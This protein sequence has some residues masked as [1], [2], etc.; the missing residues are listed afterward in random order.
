MSRADQSHRR[1]K[2]P[3]AAVFR[4]VGIILL[5]AII[6]ICVPLIVP[7]TM[8]YQLYTVV[9]GS[10]EPAVPT[11]SLVY[12]KYVKPGDIET[13]D[14]IAFYGSDAQGS[15]ITH[16]VVSNSNAMG[17]FIT[18]GDANAENDMNPVTYEQYVGKMVRS[19]PKVGGIVQTITVGSGKTVLKC[20]IGLAIVLQEPEV[21]GWRSRGYGL[22]FLYR[23]R[24]KN[25]CVITLTEKYQCDINNTYMVCY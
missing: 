1:R 23:K 12:I 10:M 22:N 9:S 4:A 15:I 3:L 2:N 5:I 24:N 8:G 17:E 19:I 6:A 16:R 14:I 7:K 13:G 25:R 18:K 20:V 21:R 11:G